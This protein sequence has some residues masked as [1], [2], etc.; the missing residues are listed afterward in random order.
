[1]LRLAVLI[2]LSLCA[3]PLW[4][5]AKIYTYMDAQGQRHYTDVPDNNRY[6]LLV[7]SPQDRTASGDRYDSQL[8]AKATQYD[9]IIEHAAVSSALEPNL[10]R[11]VIVVESGFNSRAVSKRGAVGLMQLMPA[12]A[13]RYGVLNPYDARQNVHGGA[14]YLKFLIDRFGH[15][16]RL[17]LAAYNAGEEAVERNGGQIPPFSETMAYV[18]RVMKIYRMLT[19]QTRA[20]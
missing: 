16:I 9:S 15:D 18:P 6:R 12:T 7:L 5:S 1:M 14:R 3:S 8:L 11:A 4:A 20:T 10:L 2:A 17:A 19:E 13:S